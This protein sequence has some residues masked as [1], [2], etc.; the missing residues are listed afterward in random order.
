MQVT[1]TLPCTQGLA[2]LSRACRLWCSQGLA[3]M[4]STSQLSARSSG[5]GVSLWRRPAPLCVLEGRAPGPGVL[6][7]TQVQQWDQL[8]PYSHAHPHAFHRTHHLPFPRRVQLSNMGSS[9]W[10]DSPECPPGL[11]PPPQWARGTAAHPRFP[12]LGALCS[13]RARGWNHTRP[14]PR[15]E[16]A[17]VSGR[18]VAPG[19]DHQKL[20]EKLRSRART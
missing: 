9:V 18:R 20:T 15:S 5:P 8:G 3:M 7:T 4:K 6:A 12:Q 19:Y 10:V 13:S 17:A 16:Q 11:L 1:R 2:H 14:R